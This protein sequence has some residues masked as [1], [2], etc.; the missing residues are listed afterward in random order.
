MSGGHFAG[1]KAN[2]IPRL[3]IQAI[4]TA[5][6]NLEQQ[7]IAFFRDKNSIDLCIYDQQ[8]DEYMNEFN[9]D[10]AAVAPSSAPAL[11]PAPTL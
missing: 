8:F 2:V 4:R 7:D 1:T 10:D 11:A 9:R 6:D 5:L 3:T